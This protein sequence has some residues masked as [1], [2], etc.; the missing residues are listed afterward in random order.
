MKQVFG[1]RL[2]ALAVAAFVL[3]VLASAPGAL[4]RGGS[5]EANGPG[6]GGQPQIGVLSNR[7][8][9]SSGG[10]ALVEFVL[11]GRVDPSTVTVTLNGSTDV[12]S[13]F[14]VRSDGRFV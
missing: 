3:G 10:D 6:N 8:D 2:F 4:G 1:R 13:D 12:T 5:P 11:P 14:A 9:L 7:S